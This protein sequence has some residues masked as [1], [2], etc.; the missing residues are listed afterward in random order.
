[1]FALVGAITPAITFLV[2]L[3]TTAI[4]SF[5][6]PSSLVATARPAVNPLDASFEIGLLTSGDLGPSLLSLSSAISRRDSF[7]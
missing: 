2:D 3:S 7:V 6:S 1:M 4:R 5:I